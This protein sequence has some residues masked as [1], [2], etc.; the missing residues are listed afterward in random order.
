M[1]VVTK[2]CLPTKA[3]TYKLIC[4]LASLWQILKIKSFHTVIS[5]ALPDSPFGKGY[6]F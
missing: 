4:V 2:I 6:P 3:Q 1:N 5:S